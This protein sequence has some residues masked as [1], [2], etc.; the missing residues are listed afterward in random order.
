MLSPEET[1][2]ER[3]RLQ[4]ELQRIEAQD[5]QRFA[6]IGRVVAHQ[7]ETDETFATQLRELL[8][9]TIKDRGERLCVGLTTTRRGRR[10]ATTAE[11][12]LAE[13]P[14]APASEQQP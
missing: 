13:M 9:R 11:L 5:A 12:D 10:R 3:T 6:I 4:E 14:A 8:D 7:A 1:R 2:A